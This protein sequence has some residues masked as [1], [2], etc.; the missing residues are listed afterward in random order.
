VSVHLDALADEVFAAAAAQALSAARV[1]RLDFGEVRRSP[2]YPDLFFLNGI[3]DLRAPDWSVKELEK[4]L[5]E[6]LPGIPNARVSSRDPQTIAQL[7]PRLVEAGYQS[8]CRVAMVEVASSEQQ[9]KTPV[10]VHQVET[11]GD[12]RSFEALI[13][14][15]AAE[16]GWTHAMTVQLVRLYLQGKDEPQQSWSL[17]YVDDRAV[18]YVGLYQHGTVGYLHALYTRQPSRLLG[19]G[20]ALVAETSRRS[21]AIG[22]ERLS[23]QCTRDS[24]LPGFYHRR[25]FRAVGEMWIWTRP[26]LA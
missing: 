6:K 8:E 12:W 18:G 20:S 15:D 14:D 26:T 2:D 11:P 17:A 21:R 19:V 23:L 1:D 13:R 5:A 24:F 22:C 9:G 10:D 16:H 3:T 4:A 25:G 7:G